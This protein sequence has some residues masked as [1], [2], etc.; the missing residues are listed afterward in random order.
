MAKPLRLTQ[1]ERKEISDTKMLEVAI[2]LII[3]QGTSQLTLKD[4]GER[5]GYSRGLA[6]Y[7]FGNKAGLFDF[8]LRSVGDEWLA[9][10]TTVTNNK[11]GYQAIAAA[12]DAHSRFCE[13]A[14]KHVE[15]FIVCGLNLWHQSPH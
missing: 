14:P 7:R 10:L 6:G 11:S 12:L 3:E 9:E 4:V 5:A 1:V 15:P 13:D 2:D 8:V